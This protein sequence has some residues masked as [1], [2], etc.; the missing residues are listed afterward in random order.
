M[1]GVRSPVRKISLS[2]PSNPS[3]I[4]SQL[5]LAVFANLAPI[6]RNLIPTNSQYYL[7][8]IFA[9]LPAS[10][11]PK[12]KTSTNTTLKSKQI[13][14]TFPVSALP[15]GSTDAANRAPLT[16]SYTGPGPIMLGNNR[17]H[18]ILTPAVDSLTGQQL[19]SILIRPRG[20]GDPVPLNASRDLSCLLRQVAVDTKNPG[21]VPFV[22]EERYV[23]QSGAEQVVT[24]TWG[25]VK[26]P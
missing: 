14:I 3:T 6:K 8:I 19:L 22:L 4:A 18:S 13:T 21:H 12:T 10:I 16:T 15:A 25:Q 26:A 7:D 1:P 20:M 17:F 5:T 9:I 11:D 23:D 2:Q 24:T